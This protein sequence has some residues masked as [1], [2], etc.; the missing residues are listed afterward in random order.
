MENGPSLVPAYCGQNQSAIIAIPATIAYKTYRFN[1]EE[2]P[3]VLPPYAN[4]YPP[5]SQLKSTAFLPPPIY[6]TDIF[7]AQQTWPL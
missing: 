2:G 1:P 3:W 7:S 4:I 6:L 5:G